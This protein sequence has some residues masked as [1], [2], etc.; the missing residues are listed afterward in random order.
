M[1]RDVIDEYESDI[2]QILTLSRSSSTKTK[3]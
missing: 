3:K 1:E 2:Y